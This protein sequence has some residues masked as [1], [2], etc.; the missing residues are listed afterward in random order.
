MV[1]PNGPS[2]ARSTSTWIHWW[3]PV[4]SAKRF[5]ASCVISNQS[6]L[7]SSVPV[8]PGSSAMV[9]VVVMAGSCQAARYGARAGAHHRPLNRRDPQSDGFWASVVQ[10]P[11]S[12]GG[13]VLDEPDLHRGDALREGLEGGGPLGGGVVGHLHLLEGGDVAFVGHRPG[14]GLVL[15]VGQGEQ[16]PEPELLAHR[17]DR[18]EPGEEVGQPS[19]LDAVAAQLHG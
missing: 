12:A 1:P 6:L 16:Q 17:H 11:R 2:F 3:S 10:R 4:A 13:D 19:G 7:P 5:T 14:E 18:R 8:S 15:V 9:V